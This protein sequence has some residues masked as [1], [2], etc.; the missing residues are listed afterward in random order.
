MSRGKS[1]LFCVLALLVS[2][3]ACA[4]KPIEDPSGLTVYLVRHAEKLKGVPDPDLSA[5]GKLRAQ[6]LVE[7]L[8]DADIR[9]VYSTDYLRTRRTAAPI[10]HKLGLELI[11]YDPRKLE[12]FAETLKQE[13][14]AVLVVGHSNTTPNLAAFLGG[15]GGTPIY[16]PTEY[17][18][19]YVIKVGA[20]GTISSRIDRYGARYKAE[21]AE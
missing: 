13:E 3:T 10:A 11:L 8:A 6:Q 5:D 1:F 19:L 14:G 16:E 21:G 18:R 20:D 15:E 4:T 17:D 12:E 7:V 9:K 2:V